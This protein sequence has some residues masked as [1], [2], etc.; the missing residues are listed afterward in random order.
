VS[1]PLPVG[2]FEAYGVELEYM[3]VDARSLSV[4]PAADW[5]LRTATPDN[6]A[7][8]THPSDVPR[9]PATWSNEL[10]LHLL[11]LKTTDPAPSLA[12]LGDLFAREVTAVN[13]L[14]ARRGARLMPSGMHPWMDTRTET[15]LWP[16]ES[17]E[18]YSAFDRIFDCRRHGWANVQSVHLNLPFADDDEFAR[19]HAAV[20]L[21]MPIMPALAAASPIVESH[22]TGYLDT[23]LVHYREHAGRIPSMGG[24]VIPETV[25]T[26]EEYERNIL[27]PIYEELAPHDPDGILGAHEWL[28]ARGAIAR[29]DRNT[30]EIRVLDMQECPRADL[31][32]CAA[33]VAVLQALVAERWISFREQQS[34]PLESLV[35]ILDATIRDADR[36]VIADREYLRAFGFSD[37]A[38]CT[39]GELWR[40]LVETVVAADNPL[41][42][43]FRE[44]IELILTKGPLARRI[45]DAVGNDTT[46][47]RIVGVYRRLCDCLAANEQFCDGPPVT[48]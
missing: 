22:L 47:Q 39:A 32:I 18:I 13:E 44:P 15:R 14:L 19:L 48:S 45:L 20:R 5:V 11:E 23:R 27:K 1:R 8:D 41:W 21:L 43:E 40:T 7:G 28:N 31:A 26:R 34:Q 16:H 4:A 9:G 42:A 17:S 35:S 10:V 30:I 6:G 29:F 46:Q 37:I 2:L 3:I 25:S 24:S 12:S 38:A 33:A 36:A